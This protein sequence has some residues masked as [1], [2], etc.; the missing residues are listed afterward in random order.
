[1]S[2]LIYSRSAMVNHG[3]W[4]QLRV[5]HGWEVYTC[6]YK[7]SCQHTDTN[8]AGHHTSEHQQ[9]WGF[10][11]ID[12]Q[13]SFLFL[14]ES[15]SWVSYS[16]K[17]ALVHLMD[18]EVIDMEDT[19]IIVWFSECQNSALCPCFPC[20]PMFFPSLCFLC[21][22]LSLPL[23]VFAVSLRSWPW[24]PGSSRCGSL[25]TTSHHKIKTPALHCCLHQIVRLPM[26]CNSCLTPC[27]WKI[28]EK[29]STLL[30]FPVP[31]NAIFRPGPA[32]ISLPLSNALFGLP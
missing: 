27:S 4:D 8:S 24:W 20:V 5:N 18:Q 17:Q 16:L 31:L 2:T 10:C 25:S 14:T 3:M 15:D 21:V 29:T 9:G 32:A 22:P 1:M 28:P 30:D 11:N 26:W 23:Y 13:Y 19:M 7:R 12:K 6:L